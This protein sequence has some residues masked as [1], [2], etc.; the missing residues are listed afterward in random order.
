MKRMKP[1]AAFM[2]LWAALL[3]ISSCESLDVD[4]RPQVDDPVTIIPPVLE[5]DYFNDKL[6]DPIFAKLPPEVKS[7]LQTL[8]TAFKNHDEDFLLAQGEAMFEQEVRPY[9]DDDEYFIMMYRI[10]GDIW[11]APRIADIHHIEYTGWESG[12]P[13]MEIRGRLFYNDKQFVPCQIM[14]AWK[15]DDAKIIGLYP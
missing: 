12:D 15:L 9:Y 14:L 2:L 3:I 1:F 4:S 7:Y 6:D 10:G 5:E 8:S 13:V 11:D